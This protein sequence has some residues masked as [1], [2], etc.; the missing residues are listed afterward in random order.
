MRAVRTLV[1]VAG[2]AGFAAGVALLAVTEGIRALSSGRSGPA[3]EGASSSALV[4]VLSRERW[5]SFRI[6]AGAET[7]KILTNASVPREYEKSLGFVAGYAIRYQVLEGSRALEEREYAF[8]SRLSAPGASGV[9]SG[10]VVSYYFDSG[11]LPLGTRSAVL[12]LGSAGRSAKTL[13]LRA[14]W[15]EPGVTEI[16]CRVYVRD[17]PSSYKVQRRWAKLY[18]ESRE[19][20]AR[21]SIYGADF[22]TAAE[23]RNLLD[24]RWR[25]IAPEGA[26]GGDYGQRRLYSALRAGA[27]SVGVGPGPAGLCVA[28]GM[29]ASIPLP[30]GG[31][32]IR[33]EIERAHPSPDAGSSRAIA[34]WF[35]REP[36]SRRDIAVE[37][38]GPR[39][40]L[41][42]DFGDGFLIVSSDEDVSIRA[43][44]EGTGEDLEITPRPECVGGFLADGDP[45]RF[46]KGG[47]PEVA[48]PLR[49]DARRVL[50]PG[51][52][53]GGGASIEYEIAG[54]D[55]SVLGTGE[56]PLEDAVSAYDSALGLPGRL[57]TETARRYFL[58]GGECSEIRV[59]SRFPGVYVTGYTR[60]EGLL[61]EARIP[62]ETFKFEEVGEEFRDWFFVRPIDYLERLRSGREAVFSLQKRPPAVREAL[63][64]GEYSVRVHEPAGPS[65]TFRVV[66]AA[67]PTWKGAAGERVSG[68]ASV[69]PG[70]PLRLVFRGL[71]GEETVRP[72]AILL[73]PPGGAVRLRLL[74]DGEVSFAREAASGEEEL[75]LPPVPCGPRTVHFEC[76]SPAVLYVGSVEA[77]EPAEPGSPP[78]PGLCLERSVYLVD[79]RGLSFDIP[80]GSSDPVRLT[81][82]LYQ[83]ATNLERVEVRTVVDGIRRRPHEPLRS[84]TLASTRYSVRAAAGPL[85]RL[86]GAEGAFVIASAPFSVDL[87]SDLSP[88]EYR[89][90]LAVESGPPCY[91]QVAEVR[92][93]PPPEE[94]SRSP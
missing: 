46:A 27:E 78:A 87:G 39:A 24:N 32:C 14:A 10:T 59:R 49:I 20:L 91:V 2:A 53:A 67:G 63:W 41:R 82:R 21:G 88:G 55:G 51:V 30:E 36:G 37:I 44:L 22:L 75:I 90:R 70:A 92:G 43:F 76:A 18:R 47:P 34:S 38:W 12:D 11:L 13:R 8:R 69:A 4:Y 19:R 31:G 57:V 65:Q 68:F 5:T 45:L 28:A 72:R 17:A 52:P 23:R 40:G 93:P 26:S 60:P 3:A 42:E 48:S 73:A 61:A 64:S 54:R 83:P 15:M 62:E 71:P 86:L 25:P 16:A 6:P 94:A 85:L 29:L 58:L 50:D 35:G 74:V 66:E 7:V 89:V 79:G 81:V 84:W 1:A 9:G 80:K 77:A 56:I 33:L